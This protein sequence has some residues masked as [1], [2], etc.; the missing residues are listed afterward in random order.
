MSMSPLAA[1]RPWNVPVDSRLAAQVIEVAMS[2]G[3]DFVDLF[4]ED[5]TDQS[6]VFL[7]GKVKD[8][9]SGHSLGAGIR[10]IHGHRAIY[11]YTSDLSAKG[12]LEVAR[13]V[14]AAERGA[15][16]IVAKALEESRP[17]HAHPCKLYPRQVP[18]DRRVDLMIRADRAARGWSEAISQVEISLAETIQNVLIANSEGLY[19]I[20]ERPYT[21]IFVQA[22]ASGHGEQQVG[23]RSP[24]SLS[25]F[26]FIETLNIEELATE[27]AESAVRM[28]EAKDCPAGHMPVVIDKGFGG[29]IFH[30]ACGHLLETTSVAS[31]ASILADKMGEMIAHEAVT[32]V[33]DGTI[34]NEWGSIAID[35][36]G[37]ATQRTTLIEN[38]RLVAYLSDRLGEIKTQY[39]R[40]GS[41]RR[42]GYRYPPASRMRNTFI[43]PGDASLEELIGGVSFG[44]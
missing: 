12:L 34:Q 32:A 2:S 30:E 7:G 25:G 44:L 42:Q 13:A 21:R 16:D 28:L 3:A 19:I 11:G 24:G 4:V 1:T 20:D 40:T 18:V 38:G 17:G 31:K 8:A 37:M 43:A 26:E 39:P 36:E 29:V 15:G 35:D 9:V 5:R 6:L 23:A 14:A 27:A 10:V 33:D 41:G 22:I